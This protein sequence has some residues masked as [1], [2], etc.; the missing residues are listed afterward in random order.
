MNIIDPHVHFFNLRHGKYDWLRLENS[1]NWPDKSI[2]C[3]DFS[4]SDISQTNGI[5]LKGY[6]HIEAGFDNQNPIRE[7]EWL[8]TFQDVDVAQACIA[9]ADLNSEPE[10][11]LNQFK[12]LAQFES[13]RGIRHILDDVTLQSLNLSHTLENLAIVDSK[14]AVFELQVDDLTYDTVKRLLALFQPF[15]NITLV[16]NHAAFPAVTQT[17]QFDAWK[18]KINILSVELPNLYVKCSGLEMLY[19]D[20]Q[21]N[22]LAILLDS[23]LNAFSESRV[24]CASNFPLTLFRQPYQEYWA[25][26]FSVIDKLNANKNALCFEN[27]YKVY[28]FKFHH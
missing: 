23:C 25:M 17:K 13:F 19:R 16:L 22:D 6:V 10:V 20:Y 26:M 3:K 1:P 7:L 18:T 14:K 15:Q 4:P 12:A 11:F 27:A 8:S 9:Y 2:I 21:I 5:N 28:G 24:L